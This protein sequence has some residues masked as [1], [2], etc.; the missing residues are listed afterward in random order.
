MIDAVERLSMSR[1]KPPV[2]KVDNGAEFAPHALDPG[3]S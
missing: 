2:I 1:Q 3:A